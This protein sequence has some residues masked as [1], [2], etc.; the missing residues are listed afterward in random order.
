LVLG[1]EGDSFLILYG[2]RIRGGN[3]LE[4][5]SA[6]LRRIT[7]SGAHESFIGLDQINVKVPRSLAGRGEVAV[8]VT[9]DGAVAN[10]VRVSFE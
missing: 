1:P 7:F 8:R 10:I 5:R 4:S 2:T 6:A 3:N 9:V